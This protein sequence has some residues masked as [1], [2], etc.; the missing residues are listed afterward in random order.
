ML[1]FHCD[2]IHTPPAKWANESMVELKIDDAVTPCLSVVMA[3]YNEAAN[4]LAVARKF[5][6]R[7]I[8]KAL[9]IANGGS[10]HA[11]WKVLNVLLAKAPSFQLTRHE[12]NQ[13]N[14]RKGAFRRCIIEH[15]FLLRRP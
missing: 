11:A 6:N 4:I 5:L 1:Q 8:V 2:P 13:T 9:V 3:A 14:Q 15:N 10:S 12:C 7:H